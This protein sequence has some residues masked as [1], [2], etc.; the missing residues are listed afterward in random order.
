MCLR[1]KFFINF[2]VETLFSQKGSK[3]LFPFLQDS[4]YLGII[5][6]DQRAVLYES[7]L[8]ERPPWNTNTAIQGKGFCRTGTGLYTFSRLFVMNLRRLNWTQVE[9]M[10]QYRKSSLCY[11][12]PQKE[13]CGLSSIPTSMCLWVIYIFPGPVHIFCLKQSRQTDTGNI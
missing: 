3:S 8:V 5:E 10:P 7:D 6:V 4:L 11:V 9:T 1:L 13:L 2:R 12:F